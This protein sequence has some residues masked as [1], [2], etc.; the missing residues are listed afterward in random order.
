MT[1]RAAS[2][3]TVS[4]RQLFSR[5][6]NYLRDVV[7]CWPFLFSALFAVASAFASHRALAVRLAI[8][9]IVSIAFAR[10][11]LLLFFAALGFWAIQSAISLLIQGWSWKVFAVLVATGV[12]F[13]VANKY[14][15]K[16]RLSYRLP[17]EFGAVDMLLSF[18][19]ICG[20][21]FVFYLIS[22]YN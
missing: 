1:A 21:L 20:T 16:P 6:V 17:K 12:P 9:A 14:L 7:L 19:S 2:N 3:Q 4:S 18:A 22:P 13:G 5:D 10:E 11:R 15:R 8:L